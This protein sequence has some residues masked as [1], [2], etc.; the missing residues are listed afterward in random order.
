M[1]GAGG[2]MDA[3]TA[4]FQIG[5]AIFLINVVG[6]IVW[7]VLLT[8]TDFFTLLGPII[9]VVILVVYFVFGEL[10]LYPFSGRHVVKYK[11]PYYVGLLGVVYIA[12]SLLSR[13]APEWYPT[14]SNLWIL[15]PVMGYGLASVLRGW[16]IS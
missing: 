6:L 4:K 3:A 8:V 14:D 7:C 10:S 16:R 13:P 2:I 9:V 15:V 5:R 11:I 12:N 1:A